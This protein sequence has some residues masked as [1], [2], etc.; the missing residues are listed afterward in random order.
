[1]NRLL[2]RH[3]RPRHGYRGIVLT[4]PGATPTELQAA[5]DAWNAAAS[6]WGTFEQAHDGSPAIVQ[7]RSLHARACEVLDQKPAAISLLENVSGPITDAE[8]TAH[9]YRANQ[10]KR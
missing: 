7:A 5:R 3:R 4:R 9:A 8:K 2:A 6:W 1:M 10:L